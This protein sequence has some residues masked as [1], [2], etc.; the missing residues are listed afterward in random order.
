MTRFEPGDDGMTGVP[1]LALEW[2]TSTPPHPGPHHWIHF[3]AFPGGCVWHIRDNPALLST[4]EELARA[5]LLV[6]VLAEAV[7][8]QEGRNAHPGPRVNTELPEIWWG[9]GRAES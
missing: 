8:V 1:L 5:M 3:R 2:D 9:Q 6:D 4:W 7:D